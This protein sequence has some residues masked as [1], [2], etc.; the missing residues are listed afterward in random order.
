MFALAG[1]AEGIAALL[2][3]LLDLYMVA[4][5]IYALMS[6]FSP[7]P[8]NLFVRFIANVCEPVLGTIRSFLPRG[9]GVDI[10]PMIAIVMIYL[11]KRLIAESLLQLG[12]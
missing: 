7:D 5:V 2:T 11:T 6:W 3:L 8:Y 9:W 10:S 12:H 4:I 1:F